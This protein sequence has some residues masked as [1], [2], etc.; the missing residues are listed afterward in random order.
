VVDEYGRP[1]G[2]HAAEPGV[3]RLRPPVG[4]GTGT[5]Y[6]KVANRFKSVSSLAIE[7][8]TTVGTTVIG[9]W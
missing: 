5:T 3:V 1:D 9:T 7:R 4:A 8:G 6:S 2:E